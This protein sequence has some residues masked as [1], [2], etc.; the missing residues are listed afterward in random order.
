LPLNQVA[1]V[2][3]VDAR[4]VFLK[5][6]DK[7]I[8]KE[9]AT[10]ISKSTLGVNPIADI[11]YIKLSFPA[12]TEETRLSNVKKCKEYLEQAKTKV[13][14]AREDIKTLIKKN[15]TAISEDDV[16]YFNSELDKETKIANNKLEEMFNKKQQELLKI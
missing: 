8:L 1:N 3:I 6:Y 9:I 12:I 5:P 2:Q 4:T 16:F 14:K 10:S 7:S 15:A 11:D 13:R